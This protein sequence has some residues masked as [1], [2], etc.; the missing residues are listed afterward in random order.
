MN[1]PT[2]NLDEQLIFDVI[3]DVMW[4]WSQ[5]PRSAE[6]AGAM[7]AIGSILRDNSPN[8]GMNCA[9]GSRKIEAGSSTAAEHAGNLAQKSALCARQWRGRLCRLCVRIRVQPWRHW[10]RLGT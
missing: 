3:A 8:H 10:R 1:R 4:D 5:K 6:R 9:C 7:V 2:L